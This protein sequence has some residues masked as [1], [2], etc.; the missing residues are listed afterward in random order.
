MFSGDREKGTLGPIGLNSNLSITL[1]AATVLEILT[2]PNSLVINL[3]F[4]L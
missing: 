4:F 1:T 3:K 2:L